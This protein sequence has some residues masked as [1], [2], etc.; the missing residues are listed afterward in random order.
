MDRA[1]EAFVLALVSNTVSLENQ[2]I[3]FLLSIDCLA[4]PLLVGVTDLP[5]RNAVS[6]DYEFT[7]DEFVA[8]RLLLIK[9]NPHEPHMRMSTNSYCQRYS[10]TL[11]TP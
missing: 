4:H 9:G 3:S 8:V 10:R 6:G 5:P 2:Y 1:I 11:T 7:G